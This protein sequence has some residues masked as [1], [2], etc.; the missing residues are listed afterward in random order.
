MTLRTPQ[1]ADTPRLHNFVTQLDALLKSTA[2]EAAILASGKPLLAEL[3]A[4]DDWLPDEYAQPNPERYQQFLLYADPD[5]R[6]SVVS[7]VWGPGQATPIHDHTV[8]GMIGMLRGAELCQPFAKN[9]Q[10]HWQ[11]S[12]EQDRLEAG[13][14][15]AVSPT[16]GDV[17]RVWNAL[18]DQASISIHVYGANIGKVSRHVFHEDG[19]VKEFISGYSNAKAETPLEFPLTA[20]EFPSAPY[21]RIRETLLQRQEIALLDV[22]EEDP[23]AQCHP[24]V[25][26]HRRRGVDTHPATGHLHRGVRH[27]FQWRRPCPACC[28]HLETHG[29]H[30]CASA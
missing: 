21:A 23:F 10:G 26:P 8:W 7:F 18:S 17:H 27:G 12:G 3:V 19:T 20:G 2:D 30:T 14:V 11:P 6:F 9:A 24:P 4:Q 25:G 13:D 15:E 16:I 29:L 28:A 5:D 1:L 22:R